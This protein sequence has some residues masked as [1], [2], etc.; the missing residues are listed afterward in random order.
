MQLGSLARW[1]K[2]DAPVW[3]GQQL[4]RF[5]ATGRGRDVIFIHGLA[6]SPE[7]WEEASRTAGSGRVRCTAFTCAGLRAWR[8]A[9]FASR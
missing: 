7:C 2:K 5:G 9:P 6:A 1:L 8:R 4:Y 3:E